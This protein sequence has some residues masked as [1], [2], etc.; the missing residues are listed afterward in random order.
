MVSK[1]DA[2]NG[3]GP[4]AVF[5]GH[6]LFLVRLPYGVQLQTNGTVIA[7]CVPTVSDDYLNMQIDRLIRERLGRMEPKLWGNRR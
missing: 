3:P 6:A 2:S 7:E 5:D 4:F 1:T